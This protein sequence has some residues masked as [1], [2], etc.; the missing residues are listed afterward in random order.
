M[1]DVPAGVVPVGKVTEE[2]DKA[3]TDDTV[4]R[5]GSARQQ[6]S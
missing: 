2:D 4:F 3:L 5:T 1:L 6:V